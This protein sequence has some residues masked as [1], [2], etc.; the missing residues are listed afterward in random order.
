VVGSC[1]YSNEPLGSIKD[2]EFLDYLSNY[3]L[4]KK[5]HAMNL[6]AVILSIQFFIYLRADSNIN[7]TVPSAKVFN[8]ITV[9]STEPRGALGLLVGILYIVNQ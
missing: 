1:E 6:I 4:L 9:C 3:H 5:D 2:G 7:L 8:Y